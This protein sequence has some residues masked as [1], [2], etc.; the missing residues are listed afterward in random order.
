MTPSLFINGTQIELVKKTKFIG[1]LLDSQLKWDHQINYIKSKIAKGIGILCRARKSL[2]LPTL[3]TLYYSMIYPYLTYCVEVW[4]NAQQIYMEP[5]F[6]LQKKV[7]R[8]MTS[9]HPYSHT[10]PIFKQLH[11]L[12]LNQIYY[13]SLAKMMFKFVKGMMPTIFNDLFC[14]NSEVNTRLTR[15]THKL[16]IPLCRTELHKRTIRYQGPTIWNACE[17]IVDPK[18]SIHT[19]KKRLKQYLLAKA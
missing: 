4:G 19:F 5:L 17:D 2:E 12:K 9:A 16:A 6:I 11:I 13:S 7:V 15:N 8:I 1:V 14:R 18:C 10:D 3:A